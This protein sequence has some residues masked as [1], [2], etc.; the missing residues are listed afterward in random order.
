MNAFLDVAFVIFHTTLVAFNLTGWIW[1]RTRRLHL[2]VIG[3]TVVSWFGLGI[4]YGWG[5][6]PSTDWHWSVKRKL[7]ETDLPQSYVK[8]Y[9]D[10]VTGISW[11]AG[12]VD[13][14]VLG[15]GLGAL[16]ISIWLNWRDRHRCGE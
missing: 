3:A 13:V 15:F 5:Y 8:Y 1:K 4:F 6:C 16:G 14:M 2:A 9:L 12:L 10:A 7:G 11:D